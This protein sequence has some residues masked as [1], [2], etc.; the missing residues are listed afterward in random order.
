MITLTNERQI[1]FSP[2]NW[3]EI[4]E[5]PGYV[6]GIDPTKHKLK[7]IIGSYYLKDIHCGLSECNSS[8]DKGYIAQTQS[9]VVT[10]VGHICGKKYFGVDFT[11]FANQHN[12][13]VIAKSH[14][15]L[16]FTF[17]LQLEELEGEVSE[18]RSTEFGVDWIYKS[19]QELVTRGKSCPDEV[20][21]TFGAMIKSRSN[22]LKKERPATEAE[23]KAHALARSK[24]SPQLRYV[25]ETVAVISGM[26][27]LFEEN[28]LKRLVV[29]DVLENV[30]L[31][32]KL[33]IDNLTFSE[34]NRWA[35]WVNSLDI[36]KDNIRSS[37]SSGLVL[38]TQFNIEPFLKIISKN[39][40][41]K[42]FG[43]FLRK[44]PA[45]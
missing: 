30:K 6:K 15:D 28:D 22:I 25:E 4:E 23:I 21:K 37:M 26:E 1:I 20:V 11:T 27:V 35:K 13:E 33:T 7:A 42:D 40:S 10:N 8:H 34:L 24:N 19:S 9:G 18:L 14:R 29:D 16:L 44:L 36:T 43:K 31:F 39:E 45:T 32:K 5:L 41:L 12:R 17:S 2:K 3:A 38:L